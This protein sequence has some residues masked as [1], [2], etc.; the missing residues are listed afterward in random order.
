MTLSYLWRNRK[1]DAIGTRA[2]LKSWAKRV[3]HGWNVLSICWRVYSLESR[4]ARIGLLTVVSA[5]FDGPRRNLVIGHD[6]AIGKAFF[7][8]HAPLT[9]GNHVS[10]NNGVQIL[11]ATHDLADPEWKTTR[12]PIEIADYAWIATG[13]I[14]LPGVHIGEGAVVGAGAVVGHDVEPYTIVAGNPA[15]PTSR[16]RTMNLDYTPAGF[17]APFEA[18]LGRPTHAR[19]W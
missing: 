4:G 11:T 1:R 14:I 3:F 7:A 9:I 12:K 10:I 2:W 16:K 6:C 17:I 15:R 5:E 13:A 18:W 19:D 8:V